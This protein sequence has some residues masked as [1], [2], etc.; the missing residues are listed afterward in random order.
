MIQATL[1]A[2]GFCG[3]DD[4]V[5][6]NFVVLLSTA[7]PLVEFGVLFRP[8]REGQP[9][10][11]TMSWVQRLAAATTGANQYHSQRDMKNDPIKLAAH[12]CGSRADEVLNGNDL[13]IQQLKEWG[14]GR[15]QINATAVNGV[16]TVNLE[17][18]VSLLRSVILRNPSVE[19]IVQKS[20]E[21]RPLWQGLLESGFPS[22]ASMLCDES[23]GMGISAKAS[24]PV[25]SVEYKVGYAGGIGPHN[26]EQVLIDVATI[27]EG[28]T[29][30]IDMESSL[31]SIKDAQDVFDLDKCYQVINATCQAGFMSHPP[32]LANDEYQ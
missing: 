9:R 16:D 25:P 13:F 18:Q 5:H 29:V 21:T 23:K 14:F 7:Y 32:Y 2:L 3:V 4:S 31:R 15:V 24:W 1:R 20:E 11:A 10:Y 12:L 28:N 26:I 6:P 8:D 27:A 22:N 30:W 17:F 19:F